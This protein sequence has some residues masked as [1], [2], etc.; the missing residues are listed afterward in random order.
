MLPSSEGPEPGSPALTS[1]PSKVLVARGKAWVVVD[2]ILDGCPTYE[3]LL[4]R[5]LGSIC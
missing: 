3:S 2:A 4:S 1:A 5:P